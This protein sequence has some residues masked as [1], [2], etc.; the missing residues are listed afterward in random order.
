[1]TA[2]LLSGVRIPDVPP[3]SISRARRAA[4]FLVPFGL[5]A[6]KEAL[7]SGLSTTPARFE[8]TAAESNPSMPKSRAPESRLAVSD[9]PQLV[10]LA[11]QAL[12]VVRVRDL[13]Y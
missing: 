1:M 13:R 9:P 6:H 10:C 3:N 5:G 12:E 11:T 8:Q 7:N 2:V 4:G